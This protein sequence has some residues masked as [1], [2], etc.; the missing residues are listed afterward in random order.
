[1][2]WLGWIEY[3]RMMNGIRKIDMKGMDYLSEVLILCRNL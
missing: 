2:I 3:Y 1:M